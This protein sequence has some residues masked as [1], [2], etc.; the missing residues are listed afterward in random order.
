MVGESQQ[1]WDELE[2]EKNHLKAQSRQDTPSTDLSLNKYRG[3]FFIQGFSFDLNNNDLIFNIKGHEIRDVTLQKLLEDIMLDRD[4]KVALQSLGLKEIRINGQVVKNQDDFELI[5]LPEDIEL[6]FNRE[7]KMDGFWISIK[8]DEQIL[9][10]ETNTKDSNS[11]Q[12]IP[13]ENIINIDDDE[14]FPA[15][16][17]NTNQQ[18]KEAEKEKGG[19]DLNPNMINMDVSGDTIQYD[20]PTSPEQIENMQI[21][22]LVPVIMNIAP[23][24]NLPLLLGTT[25]K[26]NPLILGRLE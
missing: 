19:I 20:L 11:D 23:V 13:I 4:I 2:T 15:E 16:E 26:E 17:G 12:S 18:S 5:E 24:S 14:S 10:F 21:N 25:Q 8:R 1:I 9:P 6:V 22:G 3:E 7:S